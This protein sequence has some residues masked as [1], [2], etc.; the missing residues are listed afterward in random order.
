M[1]TVN[2]IYECYMVWCLETELVYEKGAGSWIRRSKKI[3]NEICFET[4]K[5][6]H[7]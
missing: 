4:L 1:K 6:L 3:K 7:K 2:G 5:K